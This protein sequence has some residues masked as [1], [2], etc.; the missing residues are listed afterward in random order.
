MNGAYIKSSACNLVASVTAFLSFTEVEKFLGIILLVISI[1]SQ[2]Y[3]FYIIHKHNKN[4]QN[5]KPD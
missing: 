1:S 5:G 4:K 2:A 3:N